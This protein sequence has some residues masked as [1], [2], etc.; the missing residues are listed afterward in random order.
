MKPFHRTIAAVALSAGLAAVTAGSA[1]AQNQ[2]EKPPIAA[3]RSSTMNGIQSHM[4]AIRAIASGDVTWSGHAVGHAEALNAL[5]MSLSDIFPEGTADGS[6]AK[7]EIWQNWSDFQ[8]KI[9]GF[10][11]ATQ[12]LVHAA[13]GGDRAAIGEAAQAVGQTCRGCH[14]DYRGP[15]PN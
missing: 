4:G 5:A 11:S 8:S 9:S 13:H 15:A 3:Y 12:A 14:T 2:P 6:R 7:P 10:Q 1:T